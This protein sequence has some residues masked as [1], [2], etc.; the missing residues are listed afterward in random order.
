MLF[1]GKITHSVH[2][3][4]TQKGV[5][6]SEIY[7]ITDLS[8]EFLKDPTAWL[9]V[10]KVEEFLANVDSKYSTL[11]NDQNL[12]ASIGHESKELKSWGVLD[13]VLRMIENP[14]SLFTQPQR[15]VSYFISPAPPIANLKKTP[16]TVS[17][18]LPITFQEYPCVCSYL[19]AAVESLP[20]FF[21][22]D[23]ADAKWEGTKLTIS[24]AEQQASFTSGEVQ[25]RVLAP[26]FMEDL[27]DTLEKTEKALEEKSRELDSIKKQ[28]SEAAQSQTQDLEKWFRIYR[29]FNRYSQ[30]VARLRDYFTRSQQLITL[31][32]GQERSNPQVKAAMKRMNWE[33][34]KSQFPEVVD[35][36]LNDFEMEQK[37]LNPEAKHVQNKKDLFTTDSGQSWLTHP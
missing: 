4:L 2:N 30:E 25:N 15:I 8:D 11:L 12:I 9:D 10:A 1:S 7:Q 32:V 23:F 31:L 35:S 13:S 22:G 17:F 34:V 19:V 28:N 26:Q 37:G 24:W 14:Q 29:S 3:Y 33:N 5:E 21:G 27:M 18:D 16:E 20:R 36:L 6:P